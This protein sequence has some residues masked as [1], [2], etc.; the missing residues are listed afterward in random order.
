[1]FS[2]VDVNG[3]DSHPL[4]NYL[5]S[6]QSGLVTDAIKWN[7]TKFLVDKNGMP[8]ERYAPQTKP[9]EISEDIEKL[10]KA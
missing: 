3:D 7:F 6:Q 5:K 2:K 4:F 9:S 1:M 10:L 8:V